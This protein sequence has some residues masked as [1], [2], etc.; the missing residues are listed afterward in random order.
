M[1]L[2]QFT[3]LAIQFPKTFMAGIEGAGQ[4]HLIQLVDDHH[5][6]LDMPDVAVHPRQILLLDILHDQAITDG[7]VPGHSQIRAVL[8]LMAVHAT[9]RLHGTELGPTGS[10]L[11]AEVQDLGP[12]LAEAVRACSYADHKCGLAGL[13]AGKDNTEFTG[14]DTIDA[15]GQRF[16]VELPAGIIRCL[17]QKGVDV[18][19]D[20]VTEIIRHISITHLLQ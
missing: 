17:G 5:V 7:H 6:R 16:D 8:D 11:V 13:R 15:A 10:F 2:G 9:P 12:L 3:G 1:A 19:S 14:A 18:V 4:V 20:R